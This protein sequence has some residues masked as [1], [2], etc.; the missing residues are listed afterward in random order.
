LHT[1][2]LHLNK[3]SKLYFSYC[4]LKLRINVNISI[5]LCLHSIGY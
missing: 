4:S 1:Q 3:Q 2:Q 5:F